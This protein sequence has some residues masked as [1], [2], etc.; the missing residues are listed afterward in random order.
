[1]RDQV[2]LFSLPFDMSLFIIRLL[3]LFF[4]SPYDSSAHEMHLLVDE[5]KK[6]E[7]NI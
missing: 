7:K 2:F 4:F 1:M 6:I 5:E 3:L